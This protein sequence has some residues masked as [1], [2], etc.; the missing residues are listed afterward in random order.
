MDSRLKV[1]KRRAGKINQA[2]KSVCFSN[3]SSYEIAMLYDETKYR[4]ERGNWRTRRAKEEVGQVSAKWKKGSK[5]HKRRELT[6]Q[7]PS[8]KSRG[9]TK[10]NSHSKLF[11]SPVGFPALICKTWKIKCYN[12]CPALADCVPSET[13]NHKGSMCCLEPLH[14]APEAATRSSPGSG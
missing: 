1:M 5:G 11:H 13:S 9:Q 7:L 8:G 2:T 10:G 6:N 3:S 12:S 4:G 14:C